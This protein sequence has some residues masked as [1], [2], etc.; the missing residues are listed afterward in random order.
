MTAEQLDRG[1][2]RAVRRFWA[3]RRAQSAR[4]GGK[5]DRRDVGARSAVT[6]GAQRDGFVELVRAMLVE[7]GVDGAD[8][9]TRR[10]VALPG[11]FRAEKSWDMVVRMDSRLLAVVEFK[12]HVGPSFGNNFNNRSEEALGSATDLWAAFREGAFRPSVR[13]WLGFLMLLE[14]APGSARAVEVDESNFPVFPEFRKAS[15]AARYEILLTKLLRERLYDGACL[16]LAA[17]DAA[18][19]GDYQQPSPELTFARFMESLLA[20]VI[21]AVRTP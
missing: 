5:S 11:W 17:R 18:R 3:T 20:R 2:R 12:S 15:Y 10:G 7:H 8:V 19:S 1:V 4:Q 14:H 13:P 9:R 16:L 6:G 21:A